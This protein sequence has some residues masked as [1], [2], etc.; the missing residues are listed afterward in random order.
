MLAYLH[1]AGLLPGA[2][3]AIVAKAPDG[4]I[5]VEVDGVTSV[6]APDIADS[7]HIALGDIAVL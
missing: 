2:T 7:V 3:V 5:A 1:R 4:A 6:L